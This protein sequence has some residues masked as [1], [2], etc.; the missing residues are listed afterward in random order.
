MLQTLPES[1]EDTSIYD[2][3]AAPG[4]PGHG[5]LR[6]VGSRSIYPT[7]LGSAH[8]LSRPGMMGTTELAGKAIKIPMAKLTR[9]KARVSRADPRT[10][11]REYWFRGVLGPTI[12]FMG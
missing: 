8:N 1:R 2:P 12:F 6:M 11:D 4:P 10:R 7:Q 3:K 9:T 5:T